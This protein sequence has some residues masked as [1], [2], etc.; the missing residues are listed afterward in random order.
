MFVELGIR[1]DSVNRKKMAEFLRF[2][3]SSS[4]EEPCS[5]KDYVGRMKEN[6]KNI[7]FITGESKDAVS[8][9]K[10]ALELARIPAE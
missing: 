6:Q 9:H 10:A 7:Y 8:A 5:F 1:E 4:S 3:T 2:Y